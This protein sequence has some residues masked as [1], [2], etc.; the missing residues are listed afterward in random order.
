MK[1]EILFLAHRIPFPP[2]RGDKIR[3]WHVLQPSGRVAPESIS[4]ASPTTRPT[5]RISRRY[6]RRLGDSL[7]ETFVS[8]IRPNKLRWVAKACSGRLTIN[9]AAMSSTG[10]RDFVARILAERLVA[11]VFAFSGRWRVMSRRT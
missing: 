8:T 2:D 10:L 1:P 7:G 4:P 6:V 5:P 3:S 11:G 9:E